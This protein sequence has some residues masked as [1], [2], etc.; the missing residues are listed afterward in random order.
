MVC[1]QILEG[2]NTPLKLGGISH[3]FRV[4]TTHGGEMN[5]GLY[6]V[7]QFSKAEMFIVCSPEE[8]DGLL[9]GLRD[10]EEHIF[11][12]LGLHFRVL[13]MPSQDLGA[14]AYRKYDMEAWLPGMGRWGEVSSCSNCTD[15]Q[16]R[17]LGIRVRPKGEGVVYAHTLNGTA[18]AVPRAIIA[19][20]ETHQQEDGS[21]VVPEILHPYLP[22]TCRV[23]RPKDHASKSTPQSFL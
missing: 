9:E 11:D 16:S 20:L 12:S 21:V 13:D 7:H 3:C 23:I 22:P 1:N 14:P 18:L 5:R 19:I 15:Y 2:P 10:I 4:E 6:R 17:R 8:S